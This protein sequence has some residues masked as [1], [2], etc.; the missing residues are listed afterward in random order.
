MKVPWKDRIRR[1]TKIRIPEMEAIVLNSSHVYNV[2]G[3]DYNN[4]DAYRCTIR[5]P[6][7]DSPFWILVP[8]ELVEVVKAKEMK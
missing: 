4:I 1:G 8:A 3:V 7:T 2:D 5:H 6:E